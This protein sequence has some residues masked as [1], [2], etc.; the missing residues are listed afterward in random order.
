M[1]ERVAA[2]VHAEGCLKESV[3]FER[4]PC[5]SFK[6]PLMLA[7]QLNYEKLHFDLFGDLFFA[8]NVKVPSRALWRLE[9]SIP[10]AH[11]RF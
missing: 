4:R 9:I 2:A 5:V 8:G 10:S 3:G 6:L 1:R 7:E 11:N